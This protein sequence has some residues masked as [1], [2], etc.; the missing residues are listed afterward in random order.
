M[1]TSLV[2]PALVVVSGLAIAPPAPFLSGYF[3]IWRALGSDSLKGIPEARTELLSALDAA[4]KA[5]PADLGAGDRDRRAR[6]LAAARKAAAALDAS[7]LKKARDGFGAL[8]GELRKLVEAFP[9]E[10]SAYVVYCDMAKRSWLQDGPKVLNPYYGASMAG[11]GTV[12]R[13]PGR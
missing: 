6:M 11:C 10:A 9:A 5:P 4:A 13:R 3:K 7:A 12:V 8:S 1:V 2:G